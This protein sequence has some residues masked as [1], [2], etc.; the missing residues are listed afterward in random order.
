MCDSAHPQDPDEDHMKL[1]PESA[2]AMLRRLRKQHNFTL[3]VA[4]EG[5]NLSA[6]AVSRMENNKREVSRADLIAVVKSYGLSRWEAYYLYISAGF[7]PESPPAE[8]ET[9]FRAFAFQVLTNLPY[10][11]FMQDALGFVLAWNGGIQTIWNPPAGERIH[12]LH[13]LFSER[14]RAAMGDAWRP[15][16]TRAMWLF[17]VRTFPVAR[18][19]AYLELISELETRHGAEFRTM[20]N[21]AQDAGYW[22]SGPPEDGGGVTVSYLTPAGPITYVVM[23]TMLRSPTTYDLYLYVPFGRENIER[24][25]RF[26]QMVDMC[27]LYTAAGS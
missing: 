6:A 15:Y 19:P 5:L 22:L 4:A 23:Q 17:Y 10:P 1:Y 12:M 16:V 20:W 8:P 9:S 11:A 2:G 25:N 24:H 21:A 26:H 18:D 3:K 7:L 27:T 14:V 13:D